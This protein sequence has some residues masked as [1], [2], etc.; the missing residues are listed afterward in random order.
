MLG[1]V[2]T[3]QDQSQEMFILGGI[4]IQDNVDMD[5][6]QIFFF[7]TLVQS[8]KDHFI[9]W[10]AAGNSH[11]SAIT[12]EGVIYT[13]GGN[14]NGQLGKGKSSAA[15]HTE[16]F[17]SPIQINVKFKS[18]AIGVNNNVAISASG[19]LYTWGEG[20]EG[21][22][23]HGGT[24]DEYY[25]K[26]IDSIK[27]KKFVLSA[28]GFKFSAALTDDGVLYTWG[29]SSSGQLGHGDKK[30]M[31]TPTPVPLNVPVIHIALG[32]SHSVAI[33][34]GGRLW[35]WGDNGWTYG[36]LG[37]GNTTDLNYPAIV[38]SLEHLTFATAACGWN[39]TL[40]LTTDGQLF[41]WGRGE[42]FQ[43]GTGKS[44]H[45]ASPQ[46]VKLPSSAS[47]KCVSVSAGYK[48]S[49]ALATLHGE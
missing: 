28:A 10:V 19:E 49:I 22:L 29:V 9:T 46:L 15:L 12:R 6:K 36:K 31:V 26:K 30:N 35:T 17:P 27:D 48:H 38:K 40:A 32:W 33:T 5:K 34:K 4:Q 44:E 25:P 47:M 8:L 37:Q 43:L 23:G 7:P 2:L 1:V 16:H 41:A 21:A 39:H 24:R 3:L 11:A 13:W 42:D 18:V 45:T 20:S 14:G